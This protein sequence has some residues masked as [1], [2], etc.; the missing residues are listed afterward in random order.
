MTLLSRVAELEATLRRASTHAK[1]LE[2]RNVGYAEELRAVASKVRINRLDAP[3]TGH[4]PLFLVVG[5]P[6]RCEPLRVAC[7]GGEGGVRCFIGVNLST[8]HHL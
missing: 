6:C 3:S 2:A 7:C 5:S 1:T 8:Y 4:T